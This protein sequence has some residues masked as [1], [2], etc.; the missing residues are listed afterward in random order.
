L[1]IE[2]IFE[3]EDGEEGD[4][5]TDLISAV[6]ALLRRDMDGLVRAVREALEPVEPWDKG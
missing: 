3:D 4:G 5:V 1:E 6:V 2:G